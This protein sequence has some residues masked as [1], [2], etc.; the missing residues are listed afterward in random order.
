[1]THALIFEG[2]VIGLYPADAPVPSNCAL[3]PIPAGAAAN[4]GHVYVDGEFYPGSYSDY[5]FTKS[6][7]DQA[8]V[9]RRRE[10]EEVMAQLSIVISTQ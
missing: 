9:D 10:I 1:M 5:L 3:V 4:V 8:A 7:S 6:V 2:V